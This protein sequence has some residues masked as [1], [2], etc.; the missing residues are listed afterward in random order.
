M[1][2]NHKKTV[3]M[4]LAFEALE[5]LMKAP[6]SPK[7][8]MVSYHI[9]KV[10]EFLQKSPDV[11]EKRLIQVEFSFLS[12]LDRRNGVSPKTLNNWLSTKAEFFCEAIQILYKSKNEE[13]KSVNK[14]LVS[15]AWRLLHQWKK[16]PGVN[17]EGVF[18]AE[19]FLRWFNEV[20]D[21]CQASG[22]LEV[23]LGEV[24]TVLFYL[25][26][27]T[28]GLWLPKEVAKMLNQREMEEMRNGYCR[29]IYNS[30]GVH[31]V[32]PDGSPELK[33]AEKWR[34]RAD[35]IENEGFYRFAADLRSVAT[36]YDQD[37]E[38]I[39]DRTKQEKLDDLRD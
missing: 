10:I 34:Q 14:N 20:K 39:I 29:E 28:D 24:G 18:V 30:R 31:T 16:P 7:N 5:G 15:L 6:N 21:I 32:V 36:G 3:D 4:N 1:E 8:N 19:E 13:R 27:E 9:T 23:A 33:L 12:L 2:V 25:P 22:H 35:Q 26:E 38:R 37:A 11:D 17:E